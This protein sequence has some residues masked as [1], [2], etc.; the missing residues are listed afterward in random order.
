LE[1]EDGSSWHP[2]SSYCLATVITKEGNLF[3][4]EDVILYSYEE[5]LRHPK[6]PVFIHIAVCEIVVRLSKI[7]L[8]EITNQ[9]RKSMNV[10]VIMGRLAAMEATAVLPKPGMA[11]CRHPE[12]IRVNFWKLLIRCFH[13]EVSRQFW[14]SRRIFN[15]QL[16]RSNVPC[17]SLSEKL[18]K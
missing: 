16:I 17:Y 12:N 15:F 10:Y 3:Q 5:F 18:T 6:H 1:W 2:N 13:L 14:I 4:L 8:Q 9:S 7:C 11:Y